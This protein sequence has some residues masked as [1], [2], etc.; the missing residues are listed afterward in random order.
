AVAPVVLQIVDVP[1]R[2][3]LRILILAAATARVAAAR[4]GARIRVDAQPE[5]LGMDVIS[6]GF[7]A[8]GELLRVGPDKSL[9]VAFPLPAIIDVYVLIAASL[10][11][12]GR[13]GVSRCADDLLVDV[14]SELIPAVPPHGRRQ[15]E[16]VECL[17]GT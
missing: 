12:I 5:P 6:Q 14:A 3:T 2:V 11:S 16:L 13:H 8:R 17:A 10:H 9:A 7:D 1:L 15:R 4:L